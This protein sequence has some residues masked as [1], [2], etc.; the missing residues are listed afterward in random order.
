MSREALQNTCGK[1]TPTPDSE[2]TF[3][4]PTAKHCRWFGVSRRSLYYKPTK[5]PRTVKPQ[6]APQIK[7]M[8]DNQPLFG[9]RAVTRLPVVNENTVERIFQVKQSLEIRAATLSGNVRQS[10]RAA[11]GTVGKLDYTPDLTGR[12]TA[13]IFALRSK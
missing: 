10:A 4:K 12:A 13:E 7:A 5:A 3:T 8:I 9:Y 6:L 1:G 11:R 2:R